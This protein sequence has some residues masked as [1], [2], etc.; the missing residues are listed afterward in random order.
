MRPRILNNLSTILI[1]V[2]ASCA[3]AGG[4]FAV[5]ATTISASTKTIVGCVNKKTHALLVES[6]CAKGYTKLAWNQQGPVGKTGVGEKGA[7]G[8]AGP[9]GSQG[10]TGPAG[11]MGAPGANGANGA[12]GT[13]GTNATIAIGSIST[14]APGTAASVSD[15]GTASA[16]K[17]NFTIPQGATG[18]T[19]PASWSTPVPYSRSVPY[20]ATAPATA[21]TYQ[22]G[23]YVAD[24][25]GNY[26]NATWVASNG[27][28]G[29][30][31]TIAPAGQAESAIG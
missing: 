9:A 11:P 14:G 27:D 1:S 19:G 10:P 23:T 22:G 30:D 16:A 26:A 6:K 2:T 7:T 24:P 29:C 21:V 13:N 18:A 4:G 12:N 20:T 15:T 28:V 17:L 3:L 31:S 25:Q 8:A 5:A